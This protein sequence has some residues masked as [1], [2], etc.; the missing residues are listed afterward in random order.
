MYEVSLQNELDQQIDR[1]GFSLGSRTTRLRWM[2][3]YNLGVRQ[4]SGGGKRR[5][6][7]GGAHGVAVEPKRGGRRQ[8]PEPLEPPDR[9][10]DFPT[11]TDFGGAL[12]PPFN[13]SMPI[14]R[15]I[16]VIFLVCFTIVVVVF[17][18]VG[19]LWGAKPTGRRDK[20]AFA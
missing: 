12:S 3:L 13:D 6:L 14:S 2:H 10:D 11:A 5:K 4:R 9:P 19:P 8:P 20:C 7:G 1:M 16:G 17:V 15:D 18:G